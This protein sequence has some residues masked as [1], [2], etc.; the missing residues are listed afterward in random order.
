MYALCKVKNIGSETATY[1]GQELT[2]G[3]IYQ[4]Q[5]FERVKWASDDDVLSAVTND[6]LQIGDGEEWLVPYSEQLALLR[7]NTMPERDSC[8]KDMVHQS[9]CPLGAVTGWFGIGDNPASPSVVGGGQRFICHHKVGD[10]SPLVVTADLNLKENEGYIHEGFIECKDAILD[11]IHAEII[12]AVTTTTP[13]SGTN[14]LN[15]NGTGIIVYAPGAG[16]LSISGVAAM[17]PVQVFQDVNT[18]IKPA[19]FWD[20]DYDEGTHTFS[21]PTPKPNGDGNYNLF[22]SEDVYQ[23][24]PKRFWHAVPLLGNTM[25]W[26][27]SD[28]AV[29]LG[30]NLRIRLKFYTHIDGEDAPDHE[31]FAAVTSVI[32][33]KRLV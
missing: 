12:P 9:S 30:C 23:T 22:C 2:V 21:N 27:Q 13:G 11:Y 25:K 29:P 14:Y 4:I 33:R 1:C 5:D 31:W 10:S 32:H 15:Y 18:K 26:M 17:K 16:D 28:D 6:L 7:S 8:N 3:Q 24:F 20:F 19:A